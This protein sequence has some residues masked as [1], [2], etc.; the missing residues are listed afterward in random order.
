MSKVVVVKNAGIRPVKKLAVDQYRLLLETG[1]GALFDR[2]PASAALSTMFPGGVVGMKTNCLTRKLN[3][4]PKSLT[5][6]ISE[7]LEDSGIKANNVVVWERTNR[8]LADAGFELNASSFGR[9]CMGTDTN[10]LGYGRTFYNSGEV[11]SLISRILTD[12]IDRNINIPVLKDHSIAG[13]SG[14]LKNMYGAIHN[15]NKYHIP[16]CNPHAA[17]ISNLEPIRKKNRLTIIDAIRVQYN[18]GPG[19]DSRYL[20]YFGGILLSTDPVAVDRVGLEILEH[21]RLMNKLPALEQVGR[22]VKYLKSADAIGLGMER[23]EE[24]DLQVLAV[25]ENGAARPGELF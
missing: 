25:D 1:L 10:G 20:E 12:V 13:L 22:P 5:D 16:N 19:F 15:P 11:N 4:T 2:K 14:G 8:E 17:H 6:A 9:R 3:S 21:C 23:F 18:S 24:I 7:M